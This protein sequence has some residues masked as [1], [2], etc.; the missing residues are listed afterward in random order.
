MRLIYPESR[1]CDVFNVLKKENEMQ[2]IVSIAVL[3]TGLAVGQMN[4]VTYTFRNAMPFTATVTVTYGMGPAKTFDVAARKS[5]SIDSTSGITAVDAK[6]DQE[7]ASSTI[8]GMSDITQIDMTTYKNTGAVAAATWV[9]AGPLQ[10]A[11]G[12]AE[13]VIAK[14]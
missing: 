11:N 1:L 13:Y 14:Q 3:I 9:L 6:V 2:K 4:A 12:T 5:M 10:G 8:K 7:S